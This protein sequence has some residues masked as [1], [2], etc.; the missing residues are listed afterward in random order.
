M[1]NKILNFELSSKDLKIKELLAG[2]FLEVEM[3]AISD[4][5]PNNN[6]SHF[7]L[8]SMQNALESFKNKPILG[9]FNNSIG[10]MGDF[11]AHNDNG[12]HYDP[13]MEEMYYDYSSEDSEVPLGTIRESDPVSVIFDEKTKLN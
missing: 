1:Q 8:E 3:Y 6:M 5:Y 7:T 12:L 10:P 4:A 13:E 11:E 2:D 9:Y